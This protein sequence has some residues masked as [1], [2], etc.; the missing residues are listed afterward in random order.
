MSDALVGL[1]TTLATAAA[2]GFGFLARW[3]ITRITTSMD[4]STAARIKQGEAFAVLATRIDEL[5]GKVDDVAEWCK[6]TPA[7]RRAKT[8][9]EG[10]PKVPR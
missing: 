7:G 9:P 8:V 5:G 3:A 2:T 1:I 10:I 4:L 6:A